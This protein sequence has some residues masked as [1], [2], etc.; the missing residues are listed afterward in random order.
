MLF[1]HPQC[2]PRYIAI[3]WLQNIAI[4]R[5]AQNQIFQISP[6]SLTLTRSK[7]PSLS[8]S[9][10]A[11]TTSLSSNRHSLSLPA[12]SHSLS[13]TLLPML[14]LSL[15]LSHSRPYLN[16][17]FLSH[18]R[19]HSTISFIPST[20]PVQ[21]HLQSPSFSLYL[22]GGKSL[23]LSLSLSLYLSIYLSIYLSLPYILTIWVWPK[24]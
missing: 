16:S 6:T 2:Y 17:H 5:M 23:S 21:Q 11:I 7:L 19:L 22:Q 8:F 24:V 18:F 9:L 4:W 14:K 1:G 13:L 20:R 3:S 15:F 10:L 12:I